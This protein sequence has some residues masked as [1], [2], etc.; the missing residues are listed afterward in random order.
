MGTGRRRGRKNYSQAVK[1]KMNER[2]KRKKQTNKQICDDISSCELDLNWNTTTSN[3]PKTSQM[4]MNQPDSAILSFSF[5]SC[6]PMTCLEKPGA[7][8]YAETD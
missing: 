3:S 8:L 6:E 4:P 1:K 7:H 5:K 2:K